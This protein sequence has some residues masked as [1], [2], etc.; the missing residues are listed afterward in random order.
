VRLTACLGL[1]FGWLLHSTRLKWGI[2]LMNILGTFKLAILSFIALAGIFHMLH[3]PGFAL[4]EGVDIP[5]NLEHGHF[6]KGT[7]WGVG[8]FVTGFYNVIWCECFYL[9]ATIKLTEP[10]VH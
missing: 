9:F 3:V 1:T 2:R 6:W 8:S 7:R 10:F 4:R 5:H